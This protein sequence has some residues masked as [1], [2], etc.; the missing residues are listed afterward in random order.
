MTNPVNQPSFVYFYVRYFFPLWLYRTLHN[1]L[2]DR[3]NVSPPAPHFKLPWHLRFIFLSV[4][5]LHHTKLCSK[6]SISLVSSVN[7]NPVWTYPV[8]FQSITSPSCGWH[9]AFSC[10]VFYFVFKTPYR[11]FLQSFLVAFSDPPDIFKESYAPFFH[12]C[13]SLFCT[14]HSNIMYSPS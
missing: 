1:F 4:Q 3:P 13:L 9:C 14:V 10:G 7:L 5:L 12:A 8:E 6:C 2:H 11:L